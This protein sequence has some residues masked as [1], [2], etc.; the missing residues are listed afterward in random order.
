MHTNCTIWCN[1]LN[2]LY[3]YALAVEIFISQSILACNNDLIV[4]EY[5][6]SEQ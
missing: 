6:V 4:P 2:Y 5:S 3:L 1:R